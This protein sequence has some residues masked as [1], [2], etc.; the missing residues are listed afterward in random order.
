[1]D[2]ADRMLDMGFHDDIMRIVKQLP[3]KRQ[4]P[5][6]FP[7][8]CRQRLKKLAG[9]ILNN[10]EEISLSISKTCCGHFAKSF[11]NI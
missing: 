8:Q 2:E 9:A 10:P 7:Q 11:F 5:Y 1:M 4:T 6:C 3:A